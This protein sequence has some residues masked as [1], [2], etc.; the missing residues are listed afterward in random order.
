MKSYTV[1]NVE[2]IDGLPDHYHAIV[3][4]VPT[5]LPRD[6]R[7]DAFFANTGANIRVQGTQA[8]YAKEPDRITIPPINA[9]ESTEAYYS[10]LAHEA[11]HWTRHPSRLDRDL[12]RKRWGDAGYAHEEL[13]AEMGAAFLCAD[14]G[15]SP[16]PS[17]EHAEYIAGW[18]KELK[19]DKRFIFKAAAHA[20]KAVDYLHALQPA[21]EEPDSDRAA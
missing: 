5:G 16:Q 4:Q 8:Y 2:Q 15:L 11:V 6:Q 13:V 9:F 21:A 18:L 12:G 7:A 10:T 19:N 17:N 3:P 20:E 1:F 14:L